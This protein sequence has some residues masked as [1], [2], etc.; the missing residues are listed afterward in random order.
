M[1][2]RKRISKL[3]IPAVGSRQGKWSES[4]HR[5]MFVFVQRHRSDIAEYMQSNLIDKVRCNKRAFF[6]N[7]AAHIGSK[8]D[9]Q[10]KS[11]YQ[12]Q[13]A[14]LLRALDLPA[15]LMKAFERSRPKTFAAVERPVKVFGSHATET[16][17]EEDRVCTDASHQQSIHSA[18]ELRQ[19]LSA[20]IVPQL[21]NQSL[22]S[23]MEHLIS[24]L[25]DE[26]SRCGELPSFCQNS[27]SLI[28]PQ[29]SS[30]YFVCG[31]KADSFFE[32]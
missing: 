15:H 27:I 8:T 14:A 30:S 11:R 31:V 26:G 10:C 6:T 5:A 12:K 16:T 25:P 2:S 7:M 32:E 18:K 20:E 19:A 23:Q 28:L 13:E 3:S 1:S 17:L 4:E 24:I 9:V 29:I 22:I 21:R